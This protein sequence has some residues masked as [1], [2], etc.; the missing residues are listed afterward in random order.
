M[1]NRAWWLMYLSKRCVIL[2]LE[3]RRDFSRET[4][5]GIESGD[6]LNLEVE[7]FP[8]LTIDSDT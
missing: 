2:T 5:E 1:I 7:E 6:A 8:D 3:D 4:L